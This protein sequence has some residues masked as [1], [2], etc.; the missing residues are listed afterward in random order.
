MHEFLVA[1][2]HAVK[3]Y[4]RRKTARAYG[5]GVGHLPPDAGHARSDLRYTNHAY[6]VQRVELLFGEGEP[7]AI[8][9]GCDLEPVDALE[10]S[11]GTTPGRS[12]TMY[13]VTYVCRK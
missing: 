9:R 12:T 4:W 6:G 8:F 2:H 1:S 11:R 3:I 7:L 13:T 10:I 5:A